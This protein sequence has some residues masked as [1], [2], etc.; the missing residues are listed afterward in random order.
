[1]FK[2]SI[3][4]VSNYTDNYSNN[5]LFVSL[6]A[7][8]N[9]ITLHSWF[10]TIIQIFQ[11]LLLFT[12]YFSTRISRST[13]FN[14]HSPKNNF[15]SSTFHSTNWNN[16][17]NSSEISKKQMSQTTIKFNPRLIDKKPFHDRDIELP[18]GIVFVS[19][20]PRMPINRWYFEFNSI[21]EERHSTVPLL[22]LFATCCLERTHTHTYAR[23]PQ[24]RGG[25]PSYSYQA[26]SNFN[27]KTR[28]RLTAA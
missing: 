26:I 25:E 20:P 14:F 13:I 19:I 2:Y 1:M 24:P 28:S 10:Y 16:R 9:F 23:V 12:E 15:S 8:S 21:R 5:L 11:N 4:G 3:I 18:F 17:T 27:R 7:C 6:F 22:F